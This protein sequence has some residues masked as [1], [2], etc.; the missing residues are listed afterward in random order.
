MYSSYSKECQLQL[1]GYADKTQLNDLEIKIHL[2][3]FIGNRE[4][5]QSEQ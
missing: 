3:N 2:M 5:S 1:K 4:R